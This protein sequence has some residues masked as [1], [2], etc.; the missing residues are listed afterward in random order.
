[1]SDT[2]YLFICFSLEK[3]QITGTKMDKND[4]EHCYK[5]YG[6]MVFRRCRRLLNDE[7]KAYEAMQDTF[8]RL[9]DYRD[10]LS[11]GVNSSLLFTIATQICLNILRSNRPSISIQ[12]EESWTEDDQCNSI[13]DQIISSY[14]VEERTLMRDFLARIFGSQSESTSTIAILYYLDE[15]THEEIA[16]EFNM[17][18]SG[19][20]KRLRNFQEKMKYFKELQ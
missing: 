3:A 1:M 12:E 15:M 18:V 14:E 7:A 11:Q 16:S 2:F 10:R 20:R 5:V 19:V 4:I 13:L 17:S 8:V 6:P 9:M